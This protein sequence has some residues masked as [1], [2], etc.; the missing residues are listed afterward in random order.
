MADVLD[1]HIGMRVRVKPVNMNWM[2]V[3]TPYPEITNL[4][5]IQTWAGLPDDVN[6]SGELQHKRGI[7]IAGCNEL[8]IHSYTM[9]FYKD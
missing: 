1:N 6:G 4:M 9:D 7:E 3:W 5:C 2:A 8:K